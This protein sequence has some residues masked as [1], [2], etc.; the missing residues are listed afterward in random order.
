MTI[1]A[2]KIKGI[3]AINIVKKDMAS[4][5]VI[6]NNINVVCLSARF[7]TKEENLAILEEVFK[8][9]FEGGRHSKRLAIINDY[10]VENEKKFNN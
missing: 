9:K 4:L 1:A 8:S 10:E 3:R 5:A 7:S 6:H 2:N